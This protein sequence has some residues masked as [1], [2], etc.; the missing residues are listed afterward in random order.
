M[1]LQTVL[2]SRRF[3]IFTPTF[4]P[5]NIIYNL[6][7]NKKG[8]DFS[9]PTKSHPYTITIGGACNYSNVN[10]NVFEALRKTVRKRKTP[11][12]RGL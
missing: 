5:E 4:I 6:F 8:S 2:L 11:S 12:C 1:G 10:R 7:L 9:V 3:F